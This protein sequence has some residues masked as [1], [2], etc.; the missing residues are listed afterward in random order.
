[1]VILSEEISVSDQLLINLLP[2]HVVVQGKTKQVYVIHIL[3][4]SI[5]KGEGRVDAINILLFGERVELQ[6]GHSML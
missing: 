4:S 1:M 5:E 6:T 2:R 3:K